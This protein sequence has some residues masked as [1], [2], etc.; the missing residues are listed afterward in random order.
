MAD[1]LLV[2]KNYEIIGKLLFELHSENI[3]RPMQDLDLCNRDEY[4]EFAGNFPV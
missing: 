2:M 3:F 4:P 1:I